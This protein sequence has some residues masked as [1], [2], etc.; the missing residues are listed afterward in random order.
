MVYPGSIYSLLMDNDE[1]TR[2][3]NN[4][5]PLHKQELLETEFKSSQELYDA[6]TRL[7]NQTY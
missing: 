2:F 7:K 5:S 4:L 3:F 6:I 1:A